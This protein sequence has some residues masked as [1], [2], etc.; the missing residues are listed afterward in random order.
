MTTPDTPPTSS[1]PDRLAWRLADIALALGIS[2]RALER[3]RSAGRFPRP[4]RLVGR[5]PLWKPDTIRE[6]IGGGGH[7]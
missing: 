5:M 2:R 7:S 6:W 3:E 1:G 4:D